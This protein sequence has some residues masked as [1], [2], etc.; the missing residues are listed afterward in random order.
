MLL[1][2]NIYDALRGDILVCRLSPGSDV[3]EQ[4][5][6]ARYGVSRQPVREA[7]LRLEQERLVT[8]R[9]RQGY[10]VNSIS[11]SDAR[12]LFGFRLALEPS[13][14]ALAAE[15]ASEVTLADF[16]RF[17]SLARGSDFIVHNR[18]FHVELAEASGNGRMASVAREL[19][20]QADRLVRASVLTL[21]DR[22]PTQVV[23]EH[24]A[25]VDALQA[26]DKR[27][28]KRL[29]HGHITRARRRVL[30]ALSRSAIVT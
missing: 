6:A 4:E 18:D 17:R 21:E 11:V 3:L 24:A 14:A 7:L 15:H 28:V 16:D 9:P 19:I 13:C 22:D 2:E 23:A 1:R 12:E 8:V 5:L 29:I 27:R 20:E 30:A 25:I 10:K 26:R